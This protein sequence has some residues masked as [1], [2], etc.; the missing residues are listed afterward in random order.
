MAGA[1]IAADDLSGIEEL[2]KVK[3]AALA[4]DPSLSRLHTLRMHHYKMPSATRRALL[5]S[6]YLTPIAKSTLFT[7]P[8]SP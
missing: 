3:L 8:S 1:R 4:T 5:D 2:T 6:P 7:E